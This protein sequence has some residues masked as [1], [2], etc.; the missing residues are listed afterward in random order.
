MK[1]LLVLLTIFFVGMLIGGG[2]YC[3]TFQIHQG[4]GGNIAFVVAFVGFLGGI[5]SPI[6]AE[7]SATT[8]TTEVLCSKLW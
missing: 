6:A 4:W 5:L 8:S 1:N 2:G 3:A 7:W